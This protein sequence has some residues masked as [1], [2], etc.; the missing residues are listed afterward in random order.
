MVK[1]DSNGVS[2]RYSRRNDILVLDLSDMGAHKADNVTN[3]V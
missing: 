1:L 3:E 2:H